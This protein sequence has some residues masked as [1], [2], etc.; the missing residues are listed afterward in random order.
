MTVLPV[1]RVWHRTKCQWESRARKSV[2]RRKSKV[3]MTGGT[4]LAGKT[5]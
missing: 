4:S 5:G 1:E 3:K 2:N